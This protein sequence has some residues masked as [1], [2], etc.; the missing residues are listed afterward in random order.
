M[1]AGRFSDG[2]FYGHKVALPGVAMHYS[3][4][5]RADGSLQDAEGWDRLRRCRPVRK[6]SPAWRGLEAQSD[7]IRNLAKETPV[8]DA[9]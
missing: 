1:N 8:D 5:F 7:T 2:A 3:A 4:W 6:G 9:Q